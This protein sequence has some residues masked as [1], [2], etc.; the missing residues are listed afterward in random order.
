MSAAVPIGFV[1][2]LADADVRLWRWE[3]DF[4]GALD[5]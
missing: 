3:V 2:R 5:A 1:H 4:G